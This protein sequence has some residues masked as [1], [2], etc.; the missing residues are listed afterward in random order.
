LLVVISMP[1]RRALALLM[2][3][4]CAACG[5]D[6]PTSPSTTGSTP[7]TVAA[8]TIS[9]SYSSALAIAGSR[10]YSFTVVQNGTVNV[11]LTALT[12]PDVAEDATVDLG[13]GKPSGFGCTPSTSVTVS[14]LTPAPQITGTYAP[15]VYCVR[16]A[17]TTGVLPAAATF[18]ISIEHS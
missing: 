6:T 17:D 11:T 14:T 8:A 16:I 5:S 10:F 15:G 7:A 12:G 1:L 9:D 13:L 4:L 18:S 2:P 3:L